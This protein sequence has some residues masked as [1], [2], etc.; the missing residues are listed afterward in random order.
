MK[1][2]FKENALFAQ[3]VYGVFIDW[4]EPFYIC[5]ECQEP[6]Y[7]EDWTEEELEE[8]CPICGFND[9]DV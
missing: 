2:K 7:D 8:L 1:K 4:D 5:P 9:R 3:E 6:I